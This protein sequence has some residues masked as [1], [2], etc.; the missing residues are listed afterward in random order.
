MCL[1][2]YTLDQKDVS[3]QFSL[4]V[5]PLF[6]AGFI[7]IHSE[8]NWSTMIMLSPWVAMMNTSNLKTFHSFLTFNTMYLV[9]IIILVHV[10]LWASNQSGTIHH[11]TILIYIRVNAG[12]N[13]AQT[14][15]IH[16]SS[17]QHIKADVD[18]IFIFRMCCFQIFRHKHLVLRS[19]MTK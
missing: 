14:L 9:M 17:S 8:T 5:M 1:F 10:Q 16:F 7:F 19:K 3:L 4:N 11:L 6:S 18:W 15:W 2:Q 12:A 13:K